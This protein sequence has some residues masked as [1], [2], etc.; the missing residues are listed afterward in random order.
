VRNKISVKCNISTHNN[1]GPLLFV[2]DVNINLY[3]VV[4]RQRPLKAMV[5][6]K[7]LFGILAVLYTDLT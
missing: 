3:F 2:A 5:Q 7:E 4:R 6:L 1:R